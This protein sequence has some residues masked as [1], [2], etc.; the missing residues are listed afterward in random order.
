VRRIT[1]TALTLA[2]TA[3]TVAALAGVAAGPAAAKTYPPPSVHLQCTVAPV[4]GALH[5]S[6]C[7]LASGQTTAPDNYTATIAATRVGAA[8][9]FPVTFTETAGSLPPGLTMSTQSATSVVITGNPAHTGTFNFTIKAAVGSNTSTMTHQITVTVQGPPD[10]LLCSAANG[11]FLSSGVCELPDATV[12]VPYQQGQLVTSHGAGGA[13]TVVAGSLPPG[14]SLPATFTGSSDAIG[15]TPADPG[16]EPTY[17]FTVQGTGDQGQPLYQVYSIT[18]DQNVP[19]SIN[20][21][22]GIDLGGTVGQAIAKDFFVSGGAAPYTWSVASGQLPPGLTLESPYG[23]RDANDELVGTP[24]TAGTYTFTMRL[25]DFDG[26][27]ATQQFTFTIDPPLQ[28]TSTMP[29]GTVGV[30]YSHDLIAQGG[31]P[32]YSWSIF[33]NDPLSPGLSLGTTAPDF[34]NVLT[35]TP[36]Q[37][38]TFS[39]LIQ[40]TDTQGNSVNGTVT[41]TIN[42]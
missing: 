17:D 2:A 11:S 42:P 30:P 13:L 3:C 14:L 37:A 8:A 18:V 25:T 1:K 36:T 24:T 5:G 38:G 27:Q 31:A 35:G 28:V 21:S 6:V 15:G 10:Q 33:A 20:A 32:P 7:A 34:N 26:Q 19:L 39:F 29:A 9:N 12:G 23:P 40:V 16:V 4:N 41:V 22:A